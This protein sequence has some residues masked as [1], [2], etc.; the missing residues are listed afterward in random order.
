MRLDE[1]AVAANGRVLFHQAIV[2]THQLR[3]VVVF[4]DELAG[5]KFGL[6][7]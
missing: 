7:A 6:V 1:R 2:E 3:I 4:E 5:A